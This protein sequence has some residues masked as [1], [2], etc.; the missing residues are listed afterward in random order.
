M[1][2]NAK[3]KLLA[4]ALF[5]VII[6]ICA[7]KTA[8]KCAVLSRARIEMKC[9]RSR[10]VEKLNSLQD[11]DFRYILRMPRSIFAQL[12]ADITPFLHERGIHKKPHEKGAISP[13]LCLAAAL[14][15]W[16]QV[17]CALLHMKSRFAFSQIL[18]LIVDENICC[19]ADNGGGITLTVSSL[20]W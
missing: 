18:L 12:L 3:K 8:N 17:I 15:Y 14:H 4:F 13:Q 10:F 6:V 7:Q 2:L 19:E 11:E 20:I 1:S 9:Q 5:A 16:G